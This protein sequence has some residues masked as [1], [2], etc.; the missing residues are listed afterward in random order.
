M[1]RCVLCVSA[2]HANKFH[3]DGSALQ[4]AAY[5]LRLRNSLTIYR[6]P[7]RHGTRHATGPIHTLFTH[8]RANVKSH[9][10][11][12]IKQHARICALK[13][14]PEVPTTHIVFTSRRFCTHARD[15]SKQTLRQPLASSRKAHA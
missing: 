8:R 7:T 4:P 2:C 13:N 12:I 1:A 6:F 15:R 5:T 11:N 10:F 14:R 9:S 3:K